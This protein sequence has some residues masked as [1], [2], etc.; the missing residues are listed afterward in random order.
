[1]RKSAA[2]GVIAN[3]RKQY[4]D[5]SQIADLAIY[6]RSSRG[7]RAAPNATPQM[8]ASW[9]GIAGIPEYG[10][11]TAISVKCPEVGGA[12]GTVGPIIRKGC[13]MWPRP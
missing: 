8:V 7:N 2:C 13:R 6:V 11:Q 5:G 1:M 9:R 12:L 3:R 4:P 10:T